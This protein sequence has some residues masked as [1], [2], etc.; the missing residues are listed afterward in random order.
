MAVAKSIKDIGK[1]VTYIGAGCAFMMLVVGTLAIDIV[2]LAALMKQTNQ[3]RHN[4]GDNS[5]VT[6]M[7]FG[8]MF[9]GNRNRSLYGDTG[10]ALALSPITTVIAIA[11]SI[12]LGVP[13]VGLGLALGWVGVV[14]V[15]G[16]GLL[17]YGLGE[18]VETYV[19]RPPS[20]TPANNEDGSSYVVVS[21][22]TL[23]QVHPPVLGQ[24]GSLEAFAPPEEDYSVHARN[25][26]Q[27]DKSSPPSY[28]EAVAKPYCTMQYP[29]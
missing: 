1:V 13:T 10:I 9:S 16:V 20:L 3:N 23:S 12:Y 6:G 18:L 24:A 28:Q 25:L 2:I 4:A 8:M 14:A 27:S 17:I 15:A 5:F 26:W 19:D 29:K 21:K 7:L 11:L 22:A